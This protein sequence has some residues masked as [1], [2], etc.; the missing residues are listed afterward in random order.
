MG[1]GPD[2]A[3]GTLLATLYLRL[4]SSDRARQ[5]RAGENLLTSLR[6]NCITIIRNENFIEDQ[7][8]C[9]QIYKVDRFRFI[10]I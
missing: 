9:E 6:F 2:L 4:I 3:L 5:I 10:S 1:A 7:Q 8:Y